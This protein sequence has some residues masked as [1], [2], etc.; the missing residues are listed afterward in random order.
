MNAPKDWSTLS[1]T[2]A[3]SRV[4]P[5]MPALLDSEPVQTFWRTRSTDPLP[6]AGAP[7]RLAETRASGAR[8][9]GP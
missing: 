3:V 5:D 2:W 7:E 4:R 8:E 6:M 9:G 1:Q